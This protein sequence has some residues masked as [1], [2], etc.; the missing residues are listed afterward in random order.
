MK[1]NWTKSRTSTPPSS[2][3]PSQTKIQPKRHRLRTKW[4]HSCPNPHPTRKTHHLLSYRDGCH[5][6]RIVECMYRRRF[7]RLLSR[8]VGAER[9]DKGRCVECRKCCAM[10]C[11]EGSY[12]TAGYYYYNL[13]VMKTRGERVV[14]VGIF[15]CLWWYWDRGDR[16]LRVEKERESFGKDCGETLLVWE[17]YTYCSSESVGG[18]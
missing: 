16:Y 5:H 12:S 11:D 10:I 2:P 7:H 14:A 15:V 13:V 4:I 9:S 18:V 1:K 3:Y 17:K 8:L 6:R